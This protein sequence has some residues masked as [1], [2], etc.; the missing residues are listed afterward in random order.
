MKEI[1]I[2]PMTDS[3]LDEVLAIEADSYPR[4][5]SKSHFLDEIASPHSFPLVAF[6]QEGIL[7]GYIC[8]MTLL[9]EG[10]ILNV[11]VRSDYRGHGLG[12]LLMERVIR[13]C[14]ERGA[15]FVSLEVRSSNSSAIAVYRRV[16]FVVTGLRKKYYENGEDAILMEY[17]FKNNGDGN[18]A[19]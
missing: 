8:P 19:I 6:D 9:D 15:E 1:V 13:E 14:R 10:H 2:C 16:G 12:K 17:I 4:P 18:D 11:A 3:D 7:A 5:W